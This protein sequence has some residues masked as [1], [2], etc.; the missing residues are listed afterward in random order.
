MRSTR[1]RF[2]R[3]AGENPRPKRWARCSVQRKNTAGH[4]CPDDSFCTPCLHQ[5][6]ATCL[7]ENI[8]SIRVIGRF[9][10]MSRTRN[11][12]LVTMGDLRDRIPLHGTSPPFRCASGVCLMAAG[13]RLFPGRRAV[14]RL[15]IDVPMA[16]MSAAA[17]PAAEHQEE[18]QP[19]K[20]EPQQPSVLRPHD[21]IPPLEERCSEPSSRYCCSG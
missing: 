2:L 20:H 10:V 16:S 21:R 6:H 12:P 19:A 1:G 7:S 13:V 15:S 17:T 8:P 5:A 18:K 3:F 11:V 14:G 4:L 9:S